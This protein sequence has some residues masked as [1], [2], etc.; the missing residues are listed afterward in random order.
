[1]ETTGGLCYDSDAIKE[2]MKEEKNKDEV[3]NKEENK[4]EEVK[5]EEPKI[6]V[7][8]QQEKKEDQPWHLPVVALRPFSCFP[9]HIYQESVLYS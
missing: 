8:E 1:M 3:N 5:I 6:E 4:M 7:Q 9:F 2:E